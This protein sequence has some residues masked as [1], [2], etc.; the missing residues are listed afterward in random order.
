MRPASAFPTT[1]GLFSW[2]RFAHGAS[3]WG[4]VTASEIPDYNSETT[5]TAWHAISD[6]VAPSLIGKTVASGLGMS[7]AADCHPQT[8]D[9]E[10]RLGKCVLGCGG[11][12]QRGSALKTEFAA[13]GL[14]LNWESQTPATAS[15]PAAETARV[16]TFPRYRFGGNAGRGDSLPAN[17]DLYRRLAATF[18]MRSSMGLISGFDMNS[19]QMRPVRWFSIMTVI[20]A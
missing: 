15:F 13:R 17:S 9:G 10:E 7:S 3:G 2:K 8:R 20:G 16:L 18:P 12:D 19:F 14:L 1:A 5:D 11:P 6:F 4:E